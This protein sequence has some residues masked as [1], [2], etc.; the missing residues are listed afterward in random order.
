MADQK[1]QLANDSGSPQRVAFDL[2]K[3]IFDTYPDERP[4]TKAE[5]FSLYSD[6]WRAA[7]HGDRPA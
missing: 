3:Y 4:K 2:M 7:T 6:C 1:V 5:A